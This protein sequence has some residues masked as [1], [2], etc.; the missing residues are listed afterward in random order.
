MVTLII[1][2]RFEQEMARLQKRASRAL[3]GEISP[4][5]AFTASFFLGVSNLRRRRL[6]TAL[7]CT[8]LI[9]LTFTIMSFTT[10]K[11][12]RSYTRLLFSDTA[13]YRGILMKTIDWRDLPP[14]ALEMLQDSFVPGT[15]VAPRVWLEDEDRTRAA[16]VTIHSPRGTSRSQGLIGLSPAEFDVSG[17]GSIM[18]GGR[19]LKPGERSAVLLPREMADRLG[20]DPDNPA[21][22]KVTIW[23]VPFDV[24]GTFSGTRLDEFRG[25]D[26]ETITPVIFPHEATSAMTEVEMDA[27]ESGDDVRSYQSR[28]QHI[29]G[30][31]TLIMD[32]DRLLSVGGKLK[33][34][35]VR[36]AP[37]VAPR[38]RAE[39]LV[40]RFGLTLFSGEKGGTYLYQ[41]GDTL[42]YS[43]MPN[44]I[45]PLAISVFIVLNTMIGSV[46]ERKREI[47]IYTSVGLAP[48]HVSFLFIAESL[49]FAVLSVVLG[50]L[51][52]QV[53]ASFFAG[54]AL[55]AGITVNYSS[56]AGVA[57]MVLVI[58]VVLISVLYP[59][60]VAA[61]IAIPDVNRS[62][63]LPEAKGH[64]MEITLPFLMKESEYRGVAGYLID[65]F[66]SHQDVSHGLFSTGDVHWQLCSPG[67]LEGSRSR[68][69]L[70]MDARVWLAPFDFGIMQHTRL[71][72]RP[73]ADE[74]DG[75]LEIGVV[76]TRESGEANAWRRIN[77]AFLHQLRRQLLIWRS[78]DETERSTYERIATTAAP[79]TADPRE[80]TA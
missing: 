72:I 30:E 61:Q 77:R 54:T 55:W 20:I 4:W 13:P 25:L 68:H 38:Q 5:K 29:P 67:E 7:T 17:I 52:A 59:S 70:E 49:A 34:V 32:V 57:A 28:Y 44:I 42:S 63:K 9:I 24:V 66:K 16:A 1:F 27:L 35:A 75:F 80:S 21:G 53:S 23:G 48:S 2:F 8:T 46:Y 18:T 37:G 33:S 79:T 22:E 41:A 3:S 47:A 58:A 71:I 60:R 50:Y 15:L 56:L 69:C 19:W 65:Y 43:G 76:L 14:E 73:A 26:G 64:T 39:Q 51:V 31:L 12:Q 45:I 62:W 74:E 6:R 78:L 11:S 36:L 10:V 40:D